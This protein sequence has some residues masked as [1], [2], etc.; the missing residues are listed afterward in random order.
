MS[1][2]PQNVLMRVVKRGPQMPVL[3]VRGP[4]KRTDVR[5]KKGPPDARIL[6]VREPQTPEVFTYF[7][8]FD[9]IYM[10]KITPNY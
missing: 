7:K 8:E 1:Q 4:P 2:D 6:E 5:S 10:V 9:V 3:S